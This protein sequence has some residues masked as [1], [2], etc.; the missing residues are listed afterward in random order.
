MRIGVGSFDPHHHV[1]DETVSL[2]RE[3]GQSPDG[4]QDNWIPHKIRPPIAD[5]VFFAGD[6]AGHCI[7]LSAVGIRTAFYFGIAVGREL[8]AVLEGRQSRETALRRYGT[9]ADAHAWKFDWMLRW[10]QGIPKLHP[11][12][13]SALSGVV[14]HE[15]IAHWAFNHY[16][17]IAPPEFALPAPPEAPARA[18]AATPV[19]AE[20]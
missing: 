20:A 19:L 5:R 13:L 16:A 2:T 12:L 10:Q 18:A 1:K 8:R 14:R 9:F 7:P 6:S 17:R 4:Y 3:L 15:P 11:R